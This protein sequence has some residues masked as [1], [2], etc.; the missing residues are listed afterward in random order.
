[1]ISNWAFPY[2]QSRRAERK[3]GQVRFS[4]NVCRIWYLFWLYFRS[5][6]FET[7]RKAWWASFGPCN[8]GSLFEAYARYFH[9]VSP[10]LWADMGRSTTEHSRTSRVWRSHPVL[11]LD[12]IIQANSSARWICGET[13]PALGLF[14]QQR[15]LA[16]STSCREKACACLAPNHDFDKTCF[17]QCHDEALWLLT[18]RSPTWFWI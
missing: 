17:Q 14:R 16:C 1:M 8:C 7:C 2:W 13:S 10:S 12:H 18:H 9:R 3:L 4:L 11:H 15:S 6:R 5:Y